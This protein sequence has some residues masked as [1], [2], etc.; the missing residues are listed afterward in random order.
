MEDTN[1][2]GSG[3]PQARPPRGRRIAGA[4]LIALGLL[5]IL[6]GVFHV[7]NAIG[8]YESHDFAHRKRD[9][10]V[11]TI[12]HERFPGAALRGLA[13]LGLI[14]LGGSLRRG[15]RESGGA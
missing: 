8:G 14:Y 2:P 5:A 15:G 9:Y 1:N 11:R 7:L 3:P 12:V 4:V 13:G 6:L 10:E